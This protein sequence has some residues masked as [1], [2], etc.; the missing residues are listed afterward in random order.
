MA[1]NRGRYSPEYREQVVELVRGGRSARSL[2]REF[3]PSE[4]TIRKGAVRVTPLK[5]VL[6]RPKQGVRL[7]VSRRVR[8]IN[9]PGV[10]GVPEELQL[11]QPLERFRYVSRGAIRIGQRVA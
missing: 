8:G 11:G 3:A 5:T 1:E 4:Q 2:A 7:C 9:L 6:E 10:L